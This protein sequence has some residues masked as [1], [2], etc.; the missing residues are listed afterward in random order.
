MTQTTDPRP[1]HWRAP[2]ATPAGDGTA[3]P[4]AADAPTTP[5]PVAP[6]QP[7]GQPVP[8]AWPPPSSPLFG[9]QDAPGTP[10][11]QQPGWGGGLPPV[12]PAHSDRPRDRRPG[13][14]GV[15]A[16]GAGAAVL[17]SLL[18][19]GILN[20]TGDDPVAT[21]SS[22]SGG[23]SSGSSS[24]GSSS[25]AVQPPVAAD[26]VASP[27]WGKV[28]AAV[29]PSVVSVK[30]SAGQSGGEGSGIVLDTAGRVL[31][32][33]H[34]V[35]DAANG[36]KIQVVLSDG[37]TYDASIVGLDP[38]TD[39]A[40]IKLSDPPSD[41][42]PAV[43]GDSSS[44]RVGDA[45]MAL[46]NPLGLS[47]TVTTGIV[48][49][50]DRPVTTSASESQQR[51]GGS[52]EQ[53]VTNAIQTDAAV[54]PGNSGGALV[55]SRGRVV[56]ITSSIASLSSSSFGGGQ[57]GSIGLGFAIPVNVAKDISA[58]LIKTGTAKHAYMGVSLGDGTASTDGATRQAATLQDVSSGGPA[59]KAGL[60]TGDAVIAIDGEAVSGA[61]SLVAQ[62]RERQPGAAVELTVVR[63]GQTQKITLTLGTRPTSSQ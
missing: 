26:N 57:A 41:L 36:G 42:K 62:I 7:A 6:S 30:V 43:L 10:Q 40:V 29:E 23:S 28:A 49:A 18:T 2:W 34:V 56:G 11:G 53:V 38:S 3:A 60:R 14:G 31:T 61:D 39:L 51:L 55:D 35:A 13:W 8:G 46:G 24:S 5:Q 58:Q 20:A 19:A 37:R 50:V 15:V 1:D 33:N 25:S 22:S 54:N 59:A 45:V 12:P 47:D 9:H 48:S 4:A 44:V 32:N 17:S 21:T 63:G 27:A 52:G 16:M